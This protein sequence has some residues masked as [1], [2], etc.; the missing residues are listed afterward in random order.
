MDV[1]FMQVFS[2]DQMNNWLA[3]EIGETTP[4][5]YLIFKKTLSTQFG[6]RLRL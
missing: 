2:D 4:T 3:A 5:F 6:L 1:N